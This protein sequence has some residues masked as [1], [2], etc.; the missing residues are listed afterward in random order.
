MLMR[1]YCTTCSAVP[2]PPLSSRRASEGAFLKARFKTENSG[3]WTTLLNWRW[4][5]NGTVSN[6]RCRPVRALGQPPEN[7]LPYKIA[8]PKQSFVSD[9]MWPGLATAADP[10]RNSIGSDTLSDI[11]RSGPVNQAGTM[12][13]RIAAGVDGKMGCSLR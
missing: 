6:D 8:L 9:C 2:R 13:C 11:R 12:A 1:L 7:T 5:V 3:L 10:K 4:P